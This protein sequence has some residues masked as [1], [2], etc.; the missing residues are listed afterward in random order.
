MERKHV[1]P[2]ISQRRS[3]FKDQIDTQDG[4]QNQLSHRMFWRYGLSSLQDV[5]VNQRKKFFAQARP[6]LRDLRQLNTFGL[7]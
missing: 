1:A 6:F 5:V 7:K 4:T 3:L 2:P